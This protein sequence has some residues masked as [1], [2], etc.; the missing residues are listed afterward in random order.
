[1]D[2]TECVAVGQE[3]E[4]DA[5]CPTEKSVINT[6]VMGCC[7]PSGKC[8]LQSGTL[9]GCVQRSRYPVAFLDAMTDPLPLE[10]MDCGGDTDAGM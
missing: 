1:M 8:G 10:D 3:G 5:N 6:D 4:L 7:K 2:G 9:M